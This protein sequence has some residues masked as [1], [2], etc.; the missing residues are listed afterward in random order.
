MATTLKQCFLLPAA[1]EDVFA[2]ALWSAGTLGFEIRDAGPGELC[3]EAYFPA[4]APALDLEMWRRRGVRLLAAATLPEQDWLAPYRAGA[5]PFDLGRRF[6]VDPRDPADG[7]TAG[8][9]GSRISLRI[10][11]QSAFG[12]GSH[13]STRL[14]VEWLE[15][16]PLAGLDV[17]DIG[18]GSGILACVALLLGARSAVGYDLDPQAVCIARANARRA[19]LA[20]RLLAARAAA[21]RP[22]PA[23]DLAL[24]N[25]LPERILGE[26]PALAGLLRP[27][28]RLLS[29]GNLTSR[30]D[31]LLARFAACGLRLVAEKSDGEWSAF[32]LAADEGAR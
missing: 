9:S 8:G 19:G 11:A 24:V 14:V 21:L 10:P 5:A 17:L 16:L 26:L 3:F 1:L 28:A 7:R 20:P 32:L 22:R 25:V 13:A 23:F 29:S 31:E 4:P 27:G 2:A 15:E 30:R 6:R 12:T 18:T